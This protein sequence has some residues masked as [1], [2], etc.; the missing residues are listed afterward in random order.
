MKKLFGQGNVF[1]GDWQMKRLISIISSLLVFFAGTAALAVCEKISFEAADQRH[2]SVSPTAHDH[3]SDSNHEPSDDATVHCPTF[4]EFVPTAV[5]SAKPER[6]QGHVVNPFAAV[7]ALGMSYGAFHRLI[8][9]P[10]AF[11][12][13]S[14]IP[15]HLF[16]SV[17]RI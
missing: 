16:L 5:F 11:A 6:G 4:K 8:H 13:S 10:P 3:H 17:L 1:D 14:G 2:A 9:G 7:L 12:H 15:S